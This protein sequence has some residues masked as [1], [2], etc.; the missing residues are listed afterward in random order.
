M[1]CKIYFFKRQQMKTLEI[2][3]FLEAKSLDDSPESDTDKV[4]AII[5]HKAIFAKSKLAQRIMREI[6]NCQGYTVVYN[7]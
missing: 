1:A 6:E 2:T 3:R 7:A 5:L 4:K